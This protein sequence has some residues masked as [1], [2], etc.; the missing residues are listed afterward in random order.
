MKYRLLILFQNVN[1]GI[2][3]YNNRTA[4]YANNKSI[5]IDMDRV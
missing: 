2:T 3:L 5:E 1:L 4:L